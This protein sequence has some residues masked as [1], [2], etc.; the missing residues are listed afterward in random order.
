MVC[1]KMI[2]R[3]SVFGSAALNPAYDPFAYTGYQL[4]LGISNVEDNKIKMASSSY[5][6]VPNY[7]T[8]KCLFELYGED[9]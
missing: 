1:V 6:V 8:A 4:E 3:L 5:L 7:I 9:I 2:L